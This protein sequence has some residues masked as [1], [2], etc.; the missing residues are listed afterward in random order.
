MEKK[1][2]TAAAASEAKK[3]DW[4]PLSSTMAASL[5]DAK[6]TE[7]DAIKYCKGLMT[8]K[9]EEVLALI[10]TV[11]AKTT[12]ICEPKRPRGRRRRKPG[13]A[14]ARVAGDSAVGLL[15]GPLPARLVGGRPPR[16]ELR[17]N[18]GILDVMEDSKEKAETQPSDLCKAETNIRHN[19]GTLQQSLEDQIAADD[20]GE[21]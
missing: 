3:D 16:G 9:T 17:R 19:F 2:S 20:C 4:Q 12:Q 6:S 13:A 18:G 14:A 11:E 15:A 10:P 7:N 1:L 21:V 5:A 8:A